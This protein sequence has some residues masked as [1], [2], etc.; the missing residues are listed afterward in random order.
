KSKLTNDP[1]VVMAIRF[2]SA[3]QDFP[4]VVAISI[5]ALWLAGITRTSDL[6]AQSVAF[7]ADREGPLITRSGPLVDI[8]GP[9]PA[10]GPDL[11]SL[12]DFALLRAALD[13]KL[14]MITATGDD[15]V[16]RI[17]SFTNIARSELFV[18][19]GLPES[20][21]IGWARREFLHQ[22]LAAIAMLLCALIGVAVGGDLLIARNIRALSAT[23]AALQR[24][25][26]G[27]RPSIAGASREVRQLGDTLVAMA[28]QVQRHEREMKRSVEQKDAMLKE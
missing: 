4:G 16:V 11:V 6:P 19:L 15:G 21:A 22:M 12:P 10:K 24:G 2:T 17:Y 27:A 3:E 7:L 20:G 26:Y 1:V 28:E 5:D 8:S 23:A 13:K 9:S 14:P 25:D 18:A